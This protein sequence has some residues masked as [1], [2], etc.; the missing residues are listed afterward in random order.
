M[1]CMLLSLFRLGGVPLERS[2]QE[3]FPDGERAAPKRS[4]EVRTR[5]PRRQAWQ[6][7]SMASPNELGFNLRERLPLPHNI[8]A[9]MEV[10][11]HPEVGQPASTWYYRG[12]GQRIHIPKAEGRQSDY[13]L[14][15]GDTA[16]SGKGCVGNQGLHYHSDDGHTNVGELMWNGKV[17]GSTNGH[18]RSRRHHSTW[19]TGKL[20]TWGRMPGNQRLSCRKVIASPMKFGRSIR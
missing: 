5:P 4:G 10:A 12:C 1:N 16:K 2:D 13:P 20:C 3:T 19:N 18:I 6:S 17:N 15:A 14:S 9:R 8:L 7:D 11:G